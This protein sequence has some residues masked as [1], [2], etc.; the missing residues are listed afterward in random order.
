MRQ[1]GRIARAFEKPRDFLRFLE[2]VEQLA[3]AVEVVGGAS[4][5]QIGLAADDQHRAAGMILAPGGEARSDQL[6]GGGVDRFL[7]LADFGA[8]PR[9]GFGQRQ[10]RQAAR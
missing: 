5:M 10:A 6:G 2:L 8:K 4:S 3:D 9:F 7:A 1:P